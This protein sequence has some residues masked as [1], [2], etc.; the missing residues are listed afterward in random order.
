M[1]DNEMGEDGEEM[2]NEPLGAGDDVIMPSDP[3]QMQM[4]PGQEM[5]GDA[6]SAGDDDEDN[7]REDNG[8]M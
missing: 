1:D 2:D 8:Q 6:E 5:D 4:Q 7:D 3:N